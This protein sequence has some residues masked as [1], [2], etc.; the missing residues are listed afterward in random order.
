MPADKKAEFDYCC[1]FTDWF[2]FFIMRK[3]Q[4]CAAAMDIRIL[5]ALGIIALIFIA[6]IIKKQIDEHY[7][8]F[9]ANNAVASAYGNFRIDPE[10]NYYISGSDTYPS[11]IIGIKQDWT[12]ESDLWRKKELTSSSLQELVQNM[13]TKAQEQG[14]ALLGFDIIDN[15]GQKIGDWFSLPVNTLT[16]RISGEKK[17][18]IHPPSNDIYR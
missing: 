3:I 11:A 2:F 10:Q 8:H 17:A 1:S 15:R 9:Y 4:F 18:V 14:S 13:Q 12:L 16:V 6:V 7:G 5:L